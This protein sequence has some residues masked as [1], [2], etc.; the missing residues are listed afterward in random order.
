[1][2]SRYGVGA[3]E[4]GER[5]ELQAP[6]DDPQ[7]AVAGDDGARAGV[8]ALLGDPLGIAA[9]GVAR[10]V[11]RRSRE[12]VGLSHPLDTRRAAPRE[13]LRLS[14]SADSGSRFIRIALVIGSC[15]E[16]P[17]GAPLGYSSRKPILSVTW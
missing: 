7:A 4:L 14:S 3:V 11:E 13:L 17:S 5:D 16:A 12:R 9:A 8:R 1:M 10:A 6:A 2:P 15:R